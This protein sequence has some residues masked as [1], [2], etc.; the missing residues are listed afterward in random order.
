MLHHLLTCFIYIFLKDPTS[1]QNRIPSQLK[2]SQNQSPLTRNLDLN[3]KR[4]S[5]PDQIAPGP[6][7]GEDGEGHLLQEGGGEG[8]GLEGGEGTCNNTINVSCV[9]IELGCLRSGVPEQI[10]RVS[11]AVPD[12]HWSF[13]LPDQVDP[14]LSEGPLHLVEQ[15]SSDNPVQPVRLCKSILVH[16]T[17]SIRALHLHVLCKETVLVVKR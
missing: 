4:R 5:A 17:L 2:R 10:Y 12:C 11:P 3:P 15:S 1:S 13:V 8:Q 6:E 9:G 14:K 16:S 7:K